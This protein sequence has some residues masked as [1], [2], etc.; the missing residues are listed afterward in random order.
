MCSALT[1]TTASVVFDSNSICCRG[2]P[3]TDPSRPARHT[4]TPSNSTDRAKTAFMRRV[5][6]SGFL[7]RPALDCD[8]ADDHR[9]DRPLLLHR[10]FRNP[11]RHVLPGDH[12]PEQRI[13]AVQPLL[14]RHRDENLARSRISACPSSPSPA[15]RAWRNCARNRFRRCIFGIPHGMPSFTCPAWIMKPLITR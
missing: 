2:E 13:A 14:R 8:A 15:R 9:R 6:L 10:H 3:A 7:S 4:K 11:L 1:P 12:L 5:Y